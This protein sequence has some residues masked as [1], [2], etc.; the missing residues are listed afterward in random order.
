MKKKYHS[1]RQPYDGGLEAQ[2]KNQRKMKIY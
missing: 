2:L 1:T